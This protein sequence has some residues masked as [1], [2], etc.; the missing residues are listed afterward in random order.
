MPGNLHVQFLGGWARATASG[1]PSMVGLLS[2]G[3]SDFEAVEPF[4]EDRFFKNGIGYSSRF[5][6]VFGY[7]SVLIVSAAVCWKRWMNSQFD[8]LNGH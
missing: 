1:Y 7:G 6:A 3:K 2:I 4:R 5:P 8:S